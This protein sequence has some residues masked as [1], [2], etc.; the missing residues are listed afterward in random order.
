M[1]RTVI[2]LAALL[3]LVSCSGYRAH[4]ADIRLDELGKELNAVGL[5]VA[6]ICDN[7]VVYTG[8]TGFKNLETGEPLDSSHLMRIASIS[9]SFTATAIMQLY[10]AGCFDLDDDIGKALGFPVRNPLYPDIPIT[11]RM[12]LS[13]TSSLSDS[14][15]YFTLDVIR[16]DITG[17]VSRSFNAYAPGTGYQYCN[18]GF[19][20]L[21]TLVE[22]HSGERFDQY[23]RYNI[24][25]PLGVYASFNVN[26]LDTTR[27]AT[28]YTFQQGQFIPQP[29]AYNSR[30]SDIE[31]YVMDSSTVIFS[32]TGGL[33]ISAPDLARQALVQIND[34]TLDGREVLT[35][36]SVALMQTP[37]SPGGPDSA[38]TGL[39]YGFALQKTDK[40]IEGEIMT[41]HTGSAY[42]LF[43]AMFFEKDK[44]FGFIVLCNGCD[45]SIPRRENGFMPV[46]TDVINALYDIFIR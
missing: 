13:H 16:P 14:A 30:I 39:G 41:G 32:P 12:L 25:E 46:Q 4:K 19:N 5:S 45:T 31:N 24:L 42:G 20:T 6:V 2:I 43:S 18:L 33:K 10:E 27:F 35:P 11:Y 28:I 9:K 26:D 22:I 44:K 40:L 38:D 3:V 7:Q 34:G 29:Q 15:G 23:V 8:A 17:D 36:Q 21:G 37:L 1:K